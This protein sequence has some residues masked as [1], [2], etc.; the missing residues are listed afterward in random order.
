MGD[1]L[2]ESGTKDFSSE[3]LGKKIGGSIDKV[4]LHFDNP[5]NK[6]SKRARYL[7]QCWS[8]N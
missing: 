3:D 4:N 1:T 5:E 6:I 2:I 7:S 8:L